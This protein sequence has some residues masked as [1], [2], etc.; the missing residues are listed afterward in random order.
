MTKL[1][2]G[3][4]SGLLFGLLIGFFLA[5]Q[6]YLNAVPKEHV[7]VIIRNHSGKEIKLL[8]LIHEQGI[9]KVRNIEVNDSVNIIFRSIGENSY[10]ISINFGT[11]SVFSS[12]G[13]YIESG[14]FCSGTIFTDTI[15][16]DCL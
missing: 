6:F 11:D 7:K 2:L 8:R 9:I 12:R 13:N 4:F 14:S 3:I 1:L 5:Y 15:L 10:K 16:N